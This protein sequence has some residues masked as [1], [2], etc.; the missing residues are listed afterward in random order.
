MN[1]KFLLPSISSPIRETKKTSSSHIITIII[2]IRVEIEALIGKKLI[3]R[4]M[5]VTTLVIVVIEIL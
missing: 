2:I 1:S 3:T 4:I 5:I